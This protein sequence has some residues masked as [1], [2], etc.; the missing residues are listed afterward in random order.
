[1]NRHESRKSTQDRLP[2]RV[3]RPGRPSGKALVLGIL[4]LIVVGGGTVRALVQFV[5]YCT[6]DFFPPFDIDVSAAPYIQN[7]SGTAATVMWRTNDA[8][9]GTVEYGTGDVLGHQAESET[10]EIHAVRLTGLE[11]DTVYSYQVQSGGRSYDRSS[12]RTAPDPDGEV[13]A[14]V[15][16]DTGSGDEAQR[17]IAEVMAGIDADL[18]LHTGDVVYK[19]GGACHYESRYY[20]PYERMIDSVPVFPVLGNHDVRTDNGEPFLDAFAL[21][22]ES[23]G[24]ERYY[25]FDY[26]PMHVTALDS[27]LYYGDDSI[28]TEA[29]KAW[30]RE[31]LASTDRPWKVVVIHRPP[32][33][34]SPYHGGDQQILEDLVSI[35]EE[36]GVDVVF[37]G[38]EHAYERLVPINGITYFVTGGGGG[39]L[40]GAGQSA[41]TAMSLL[42]Y[43]TLRVQVS[44]DRM[45][46]EAIGIDGQVFDRVQITDPDDRPTGRSL[47]LERG[48]DLAEASV[49][50]IFGVDHAERGLHPAYDEGIHV[51]RLVLNA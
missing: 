30:L 17:Q 42:D 7:V 12:F 26:G 41:L 33:S 49:K 44:P 16:G 48:A 13:T 46:I 4:I 6:S 36:G 43:H 27:E 19:R 25:S 9:D 21:P 34:S 29:Q 3:R 15:V 11:P 32:Y 39:D 40:R 28:A 37:A 38:H 1:M 23:S 47:P 20:D 2:P 45:L 18:L 22:Q 31:D 24:T 8:V 5:G 10:A 51:E 14:I 50:L 35:F